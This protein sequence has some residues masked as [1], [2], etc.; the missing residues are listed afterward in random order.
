[1]LDM[2]GI[3]SSLGTPQVIPDKSNNGT[4]TIIGTTPVI[5]YTCPTGKKSII[6]AL[7][8][9][10]TSYGAGTYIRSLVNGIETR[11]GTVIEFAQVNSLPAGQIILTAGQTVSLTGDSAANNSSAEYNVTYQELPT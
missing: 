5:I 1:M 3:I 11:R 2:V 7:S 9:A 8:F 4:S 10:G 6:K